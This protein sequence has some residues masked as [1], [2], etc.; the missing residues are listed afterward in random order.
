MPPE[1]DPAVRLIIN[2]INTGK[3]ITD[4]V[5]TGDNIPDPAE[6][7]ELPE[8]LDA[9]GKI[10]EVEREGLDNI[11]TIQVDTSQ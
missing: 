9:T 5:I 4:V 2:D 10:I 6:W 11:F 3:N 7:T 1:E 8:I